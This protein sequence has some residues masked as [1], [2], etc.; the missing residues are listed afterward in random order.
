MEELAENRTVRTIREQTEL[1]FYN[2]SIS[3]RT[4]RRD[5]PICGAPAWRYMYHTLHYCDRWF[6]NPERFTEPWLHAPDLDRVDEPCG[7]VLSD[8]ELAAYFDYVRTKILRY[9]CGLTDA[10]LYGKPEGCGSTRLELIFGQ[11]RHFMCHIGI[12]NGITI[13]HTG[14]YPLV[15]GMS[16]WKSSAYAGKLYEE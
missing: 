10:E 1:L 4:C 6:I 8:T 14:Q 11:F 7:A 12:L 15:L 9:L 5:W 13:A 3:M 2:M 16:K